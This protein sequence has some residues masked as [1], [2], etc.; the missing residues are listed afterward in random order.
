M[1][2]SHADATVSRIAAD[3]Y[4]RKWSMMESSSC[5]STL[6]NTVDTYVRCPLKGGSI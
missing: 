6:H 5:L 4:N 1:V 2:A 3:V